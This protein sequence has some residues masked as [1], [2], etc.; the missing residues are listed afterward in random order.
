MKAKVL[1]VYDEGSLP[2]T[3]LIGAKGLAILIDVDGERTM[4]GTG[5]RGNY[6]M[7]NMG[8]LSIDPNSVDRVVI[9]HMHSDHTGGLQAFLERRDGVTDV[10][11]TPDHGDVRKEMILGIPVRRSGFPKV[12]EELSRKM[13]II[14]VSGRMQLSENLFIAELPPGDRGLREN[15]LILMTK[16]G[17]TMICG[18]CHCGL[19]AA[20]A[21]VEEVTGK[22]VTAIL[23]GTHLTGL[24]KEDVHEV[25]EALIESGPPALYLNHC[26]GVTQKMRLREKLGLKAVC[27]FYVGTEIQFDI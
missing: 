26:S 10:F 16:N 6:L 5:L 1:S 15:V 11:A 22:K 21:C 25:A 14:A 12:S 24:R 13:N 23:G 3:P 19:S 7:H 27:D 4:F 2:G 20:T 17:A 9:S 18:C 8:H